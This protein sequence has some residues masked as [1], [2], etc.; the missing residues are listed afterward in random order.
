MK[1][2]ESPKQQIIVTSVP[3]AKPTTQNTQNVPIIYADSRQTNLIS[4]RNN[5]ATDL[6]ADHELFTKHSQDQVFPAT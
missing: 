1:Q 6:I 4:N 5:G 2:Q 3:P